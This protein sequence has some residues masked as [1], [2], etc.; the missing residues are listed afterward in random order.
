ML[1]IHTDIYVHVQEF[2]LGNS[3]DMIVQIHK[4]CRHEKGS[5]EMFR[6]W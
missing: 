5:F 3:I 2:D 6:R 1:H 4:V